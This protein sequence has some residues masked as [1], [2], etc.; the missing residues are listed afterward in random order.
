MKT[1]REDLVKLV[2][3]LNNREAMMPKSMEQTVKDVVGKLMD[4]LVAKKK[5][6]T[7]YKITSLKLMDLELL[8][9][10]VNLM[11]PALL[12]SMLSEAG[13]MLNGLRVT[14]VWMREEDVAG[15]VVV[16]EKVAVAV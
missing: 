11:K 4:A 16:E 1:E 7:D 14:W 6:I 15:E 8:K 2:A 5:A 3:V 13:G 9:A 12:K 10:T